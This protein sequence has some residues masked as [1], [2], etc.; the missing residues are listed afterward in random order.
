MYA[1][2]IK[3]LKEQLGLKEEEKED[4]EQ[5]V[6]EIGYEELTELSQII[7][8]DEGEFKEDSCLAIY[9]N[10]NG[11]DWI[12]KLKY[13]KL[14]EDFKGTIRIHRKPVHNKDRIQILI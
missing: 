11:S 12:E 3:S 5:K 2:Q 9:D 10:S 13:R 7:T 1:E 6:T 4:E 8:G 14:P